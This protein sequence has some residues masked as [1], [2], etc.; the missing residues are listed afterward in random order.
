MTP[1]TALPVSPSPADVRLLA[2]L[3]ERLE[4]SPAPVDPG[5]YRAV[6]ERLAQML[7]AA[8][9]GLALT[10]L[11]DTH[12]AAAEV[13]ENLHYQH[14]G[15]CRSPLEPALAAEIG[16]RAAIARA[17]QHRKESSINGKN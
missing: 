6:V 11:L 9:P 2:Q 13:Y 7:V 17:Q 10:A 16:A 3:T 5:Q 4:R 8:T 14:A 12:P 1:P 15:L